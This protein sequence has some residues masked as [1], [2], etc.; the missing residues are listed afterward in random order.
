LSASRACGC[1]FA[2]PWECAR[3]RAG[4]AR[5]PAP[6]SCVPCHAGAGGAR[7]YRL[8]EFLRSPAELGLR[9]R[10]VNDPSRGWKI[11]PGSNER[12]DFDRAVEVRF[13]LDDRV[14]L[15]VAELSALLS[16][17]ADELA[18]SAAPKP[19]GLAGKVG[20]GAGLAAAGAAV[21]Y[22][23]G[24]LVC[25]VGFLSAIPI[26]ASFTFWLWTLEQ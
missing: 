1:I 10:Y 24:G 11:D 2:D 21:A 23:A 6:C 4:G 7:R 22:V 26:A 3:N 8:R 20:A 9:D 12:I 18:E 14:S 16:R 5:P 13:E 19:L 15:K 17:L 25:A